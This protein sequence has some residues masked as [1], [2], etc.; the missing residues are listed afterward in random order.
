[1]APG[2]PEKYTAIARG[3]ERLIVERQLKIAVIQAQQEINQEA[4]ILIEKTNS[5]IISEIDKYIDGL[6]DLKI[7]DLQENSEYGI[8]E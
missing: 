6:G 1:M 8:I 3:I 2:K 5:D 7:S 4:I